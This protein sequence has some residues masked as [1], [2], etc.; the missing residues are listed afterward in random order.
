MSGISI[1]KDIRNKLLN[2]GIIYVDDKIFAYVV[3][4]NTLYP[5]VIM[6][7]QNVIANYTKDGNVSDNVTVDITVVHD[8][9][10]QT[11]E[12]VERIREI[13][14]NTKYNSIVNCKLV[15]NIEEYAE[16]AYI[17]NLTFS[18]ITK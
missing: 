9:Y 12:I 2:D 4:E 6:K 5:F 3:E 18:I 11:V 13:L 17:S 15:S 14:E 1:L 10:S 16:N 8:K 7:K